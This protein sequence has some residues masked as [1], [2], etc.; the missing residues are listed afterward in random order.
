MRRLKRAQILLASDS[1]QGEEAIA[2]MPAERKSNGCSTV[3]RDAEVPE[4][5]VR[6]R[7]SVPAVL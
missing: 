6:F 7:Q 4:V 5:L 2:H 3:I 1:G